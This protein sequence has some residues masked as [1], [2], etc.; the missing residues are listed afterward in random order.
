MKLW[1]STAKGR[2]KGTR[3]GSAKLPVAKESVK[4]TKP[5]SAERPVRLQQEVEQ[6]L[7]GIGT[8]H[9]PNEDR[10]LIQDG[11]RG[12]AREGS[13]GEGEGNRNG[14]TREQLKRVEELLKGVLLELANM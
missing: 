4:S 5:A 10:D 2:V 3:L 13:A 12:S 9:K 7:S 1:L 14:L 8:V 11:G 6:I